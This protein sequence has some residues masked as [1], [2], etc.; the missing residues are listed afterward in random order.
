MVLRSIYMIFF[1]QFQ[2]GI[3]YESVAYEKGVYF[4]EAALEGCHP[5]EI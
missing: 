3:A 5:R 1:C 4:T 2:P